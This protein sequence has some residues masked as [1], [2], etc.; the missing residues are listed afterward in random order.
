MMLSR[1]LTVL[2]GAA[3][4][5]LA[6]ANAA[7]SQ[8]KYAHK[9]PTIITGVRIIDGLGNA[10]KEKQDIVLENGKIAGI[11][12]SGSLKAPEG[13]LKIDG[14]GLTAMPGLIDMHVHLYGGW[15]N[16]FIVGKRYEQTFDDKSIQQ[17]LSAHLY[18]GVTTLLDV[19]NKHDYI[20]K[21]RDRIN[22]GELMGPR[23][24][25]VGSPFSQSPGGWDD[26]SYLVTSLDEIPAKLDS[27]KKDGIEII[28]LYTGISH[29][30]AYVLIREAHKRGM[31]AIADFWAL[32][33]NR[34]VMERTG[35]DGWAHAGGFSLLPMADHEW[36][37]KND[38]F[39]IA[40]AN[41]GQKLSGARVAEEGGKQLMLKE[42]LIV[43]I[44]GKSAVAHFYE[45]YDTAV[46]EASYEGP[47]SFYQSFGFGDMKRFFP[48]FL[49]NIGDAY[50]AGVTIACGTDAPF[51]A[52]WPGEAMHFEME[53]LVRAG[54]PPLEV[55][56]AC[57]SNAAQFLR[58]KDKFGALQVGLSADILIVRG[59]PAKNI[60]DSRNVRHVFLRGKQVDRNSL[61]LKK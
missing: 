48:N 7:W 55:I 27:Y 35:L 40:T 30:T 6:F 15:G 34:G 11:G 16:G 31:K 13:A 50:K 33:M 49:K 20:V 45:I 9:G 37:A 29:Y 24:F 2:V 38:R 4:C 1:K 43:N 17:T 57:T 52:V 54:L 3:L 26:G 10:P 8:P 12:P 21:T 18:S 22:G 56:K 47:K 46:R 19:G 5:L 23:V 44:W 32:N 39:L 36:T 28:K 42:P 51:P 25:T 58:R 59:N 60:S 41:V 14:K 53:L 61:K